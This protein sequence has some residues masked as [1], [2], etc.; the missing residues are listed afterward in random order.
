MWRMLIVAA[1]A[2]G[3]CG[4]SAEAA[5][6]QEDKAEK[7]LN[8]RPIE[9]MPPS[10][11]AAQTR[12]SKELE[13]K[14]SFVFTENSLS[15]VVKYLQEHHKI[16]IQLD[17]KAL[18]DA[19]IGPET[20]VTRTVKDISLRSAL[21]MMLGALDLTYIIKNEALLI[22]TPDK[23]ANELRTKVYPVSDLTMPAPGK[24]SGESYID[25]VDLITTTIM[26]TTWDEVGG[27]G[28]VQALRKARSLVVSQTEEVH[29]E[30]LGLLT[31]LREARDGQPPVAQV[32]V[33]ESLADSLWTLMHR[34]GRKA[35]VVNW[36]QADGVREQAP[37]RRQKWAAWAG[38]EVEW[39]AGC[40]ESRRLGAGG[41]TARPGGGFSQAEGGASKR[42]LAVGSIGPVR[43]G[44]QGAATVQCRPQVVV[45]DRFDQIDQDVFLLR[46]EDEVSI[47][48]SGQKDDRRRPLFINDGGG[49]GT[50][51]AGHQVVG[52]NDVGLSRDTLLDQGLAAVGHCYHCV[53]LL[54]E[55]V[56][57]QFPHR[58][59]V[60]GHRDPQGRF[61]RSVRRFFSGWQ[62]HRNL[63]WSRGNVC[64]HCPIFPPASGGATGMPPRLPGDSPFLVRAAR[65]NISIC[66]VLCRWLKGSDSISMRSK[67]PAGCFR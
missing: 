5:R 63:D 26:P 17:V 62:R 40:F 33:L 41:C 34:R 65:A 6:A 31:A 13:E 57:D 58:A 52:D 7:K 61:F 22:T 39:A 9:V 16:D 11:S 48:E 37:T 20:P 45:A 50:I 3:L 2:S 53:P 12:I 23:A 27:P 14:T 47:A 1:C 60:V 32:T 44:Q 64:E 21:R 42:L 38:A 67:R 54:A 8:L 19:S 28:S 43:A 51:E 66:V 55:H 4:I 35:E 29:E 18:E 25:L 49:V 46:L 24:V 59:I 15:D 36:G 30:I 56:D 10:E